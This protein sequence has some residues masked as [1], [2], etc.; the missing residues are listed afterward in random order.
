MSNPEKKQV[1]TFS[2]LNIML[3]LAAIATAGY[4]IYFFYNPANESQDSNPTDYFDNLPEEVVNVTIKDNESNMTQPASAQPQPES[5]EADAFFI[6]QES[7]PE[8]TPVVEEK[9]LPYLLQEST[10]I[11]EEDYME[12]V[13][14]SDQSIY[15]SLTEFSQQSSDILSLLHID[16]LRST[17]VFVENFSQGVFIPNFSPM[18]PPKKSFM[19]QR[20]G[21]KIIVAPPS[22]QRYDNYA[23]YIYSF[24]SKGFVKYYQT[25]KPSIDE[26]YAEIAPPG[27]NFDD[28]LNKAIEMA[29]STP[30]IYEDIELNSPS[31]MY[32][33][34]DPALESLNNAQKLLLRMGPH[35]LAKIKHKLRNIQAEL[36]IIN[37]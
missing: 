32:L 11:V 27:S 17:I 5:T 28:T 10:E 14:A 6:R 20:K 7:E 22:Y 21:D 13:K 30:I 12:Q 9:D 25:L 16:I 35:N 18:N 34:S 33:Y 29:L 26:I 15:S 36:A 4:L 19:A 8:V 37:N 3:I 24:D 2:W 23:D 1:S 31:V